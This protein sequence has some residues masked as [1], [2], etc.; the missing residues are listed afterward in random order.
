M[1]LVLFTTHS[2]SPSAGLL[3]DRGVVALQDFTSLEPIIDRFE[4]FR[5]TLER[6]ISSGEAVPV[7]EVQLLPPLPR[8]GKILYSTAT[9]SSQPPTERAQLLF[10][11]KSAES[12]IGP[13]QT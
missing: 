4:E 1:K 13:G 12:V 9:Y 7:A 3:T 5:P 2:A 11:L 6:A 8:P 10:T